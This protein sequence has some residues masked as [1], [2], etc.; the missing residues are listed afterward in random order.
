MLDVTAIQAAIREFGFDGWLLYDFRGSNIL[1]RR[2]LQISPQAMGSRRFFYFI[3]AKGEPQ[4]LVHRIESG[5]GPPPLSP[6]GVKVT[7]NG[8]TP[9]RGVP[10]KFGPT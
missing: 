3:P 8:T 9:S 7:A 10:V 1:A 5:G 4:K 6:V 2:I